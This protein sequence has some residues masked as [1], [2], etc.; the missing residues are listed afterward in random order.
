MRAAEIQF[1]VSENKHDPRTGGVTAVD[2]LDLPP[3]LNQILR[4]LL[5][6]RSMTASK[7][8]DA[9]AELP[10]S[11]WQDTTDLPM[12]LDVLVDQQW[13]LRTPDGDSKEPEP[14]YRINLRAKARHSA[15]TGGWEAF[16]C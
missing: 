11:L 16:E 14:S 5:L 9:L 15:A 12:A 10:D 4:V 1:W 6:D 13:L 2:L 8:R 3:A 7:L